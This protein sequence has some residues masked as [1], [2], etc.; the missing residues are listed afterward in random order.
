MKKIISL[1]FFFSPLVAFC[2]N[3]TGTWE[4][5]GGGVTY[6]KLVVK[7]RGDSLY[8]Y[9]YDEGGGYCKATFAAIYYPGKKR[10]IGNGVK[11]LINSGTHAL[12]D[13]DLI[14]SKEP[15]GEFLRENIGEVGFLDRLFGNSSRQYLKKVSNKTEI[16][17]K[18]DP[19]TKRTVIKPREIIK[20]EESIKKTT[21]VIKKEPVKKPPVVIAKPPVKPVTKA[22]VKNIPPV[23]V[24]TTSK[25]VAKKIIPLPP[26][27][28]ALIKKKDERSSKLVQTIYTS[29]DSI[30]MF[31]YDNGEVDG[32]TVTVFFDNSVILDRYRISDKAKEISLPVSK[33]G[34]LHTIELFA[35]NLGTIPPNTALIIIIADKKRYE[36][37][38]SYDL[39]TNARIVIQYQE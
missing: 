33:S 14:Y 30:K 4:G 19:E 28:V 37:R 21:P 23:R 20:E 10:L 15:G 9:T 7:H 26:A 16:P 31:V 5:N 2:Q 13:Y 1:I 8:G 3:L 39:Q 34:K 36:L 22:P 6:I 25:I 35:N 29:A 17:N 12:T 32:D 38:A 27:P 11:M 18:T 24:D